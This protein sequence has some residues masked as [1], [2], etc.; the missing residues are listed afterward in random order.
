MTENHARGAELPMNLNSQQKRQ[1]DEWLA[2]SDT[3]EH[4]K[5]MAKANRRLGQKIN[6]LA[7]ASKK[8]VLSV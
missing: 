7:R 6:A 2:S 3:P 1:L 4:Y 5:V 8:D